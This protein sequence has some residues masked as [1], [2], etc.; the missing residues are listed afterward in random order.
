MKHR[1]KHTI[2]V[3]IDFL[4]R[5][6]TRMS[7]FTVSM[8]VVYVLQKYLLHA[9]G[10]QLKY[11]VPELYT[12]ALLLSVLK[13]KWRTAAEWVV[14]VVAGC[15]S[16]VEAFLMNRFH[17]ELSCQA[18]QLLM[19]T[20]GDEATQFLHSFVFTGGA[21]KYFGVWA[22]GLAAAGGIYLIR[23]KGLLRPW[24]AKAES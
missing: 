2:A 14:I 21:L 13:G 24:L 11:V 15:V 9:Q 23:A 10:I 19:E 18:I 12:W 4:A 17:I 6:F 7:A 1:L 8:L 5:P 22:V 16:V 20:N 3:C